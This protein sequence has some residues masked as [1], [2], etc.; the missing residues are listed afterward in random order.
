MYQ[1]DKY[2]QTMVDA[3]VEEFRDQVRR[4]IAGDINDDQFKPL[5][6]KN[7]I[8]LQLHAYMLR[9]RS[10]EHTS[11]LPT[12]M[13]ISYAVLGLKKKT[14]INIDNRDS[15]HNLNNQHNN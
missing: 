4:R 10:E 8:Y 9:V 2:D 12:L 14:K 3:R 15:R 5:R 11:E 13:R 7:G 6:L 1:Y